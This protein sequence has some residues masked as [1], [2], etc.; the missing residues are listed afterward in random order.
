MKALRSLFYLHFWN[1]GVRTALIV[2]L[3][4]IAAEFTLSYSTVGLLG[5]VQAFYAVFFALP[6]AYIAAKWGRMRVLLI[7]LLLYS[8]GCVA[9]GL[10]LTASTLIP[11]F[12][13]GCVGFGVFHV[14]G[15]SQVTQDS[16]NGNVGRNMGN[17]TAFGDLG[18]IIVSSAAVFL[19]AYVGWRSVA[20]LLGIAGVALFV[21]LRLTTRL[22]EQ[23]M[24]E[25]K[26]EE[27]TIAVWLYSFVAIISNTKL[28]G[29]GA[30]AFLDSMASNPL[31]IFLPFMLLQK[32][33][34][35][36]ALG[37]FVAG[38]FA[39]NFMGKFGLGRAVDTYGNKNV[40]VASEVLMAGTILL[41]TVSSG[42]AYL[43]VTATLMGLFSKG[44]SPVITTFFSQHGSR[45]EKG[46]Y[47]KVF[48]ISEFFVATAS[49]LSPFALGIVADHYNVIVVFY[50][51][52]ALALIATVPI[53]LTHTRN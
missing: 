17:F 26:K 16:S 36:A 3:P 46:S 8:F 2:L 23:S 49:A 1:D 29:I 41:F 31:I 50:L 15:F 28:L 42:W 25:T 34:G 47:E 27:A 13:I 51:C 48:A 5:G 44:T 12:I 14:I 21:V 33:V 40:F 43:L 11:V 19:V 35:A 45:E 24:Q 4:F 7:A 37:L 38:Y 9:I 30:S 53:L 20:I 18:R 39:G 22:T 52:A 10:S 32:G 6:A